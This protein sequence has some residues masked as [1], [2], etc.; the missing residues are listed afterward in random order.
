MLNMGFDYILAHAFIGFLAP[1]SSGR[2]DHLLNLAL[3][4]W[5]QL[6]SVLQ[7]GPSFEGDTYFGP[8]FFIYFLLTNAAKCLRKDV[9]MAH[10]LF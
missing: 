1:Y 5:A 2:Q 10:Y 3:I 8:H 7:I 4:V 6:Q 9:P